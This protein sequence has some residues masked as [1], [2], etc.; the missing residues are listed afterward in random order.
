MNDVTEKMARVVAAKF[1]AKEGIDL[2]LDPLAF[3]LVLRAC[4][5]ARPEMQRRKRASVVLPCITRNEK[6]YVHLDVMVFEHEVSH[7]SGRL[8]GSCGQEPSGREGGGV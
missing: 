5:Q 6:G 4:E 3:E 8:A 1:K 7:D 2:S